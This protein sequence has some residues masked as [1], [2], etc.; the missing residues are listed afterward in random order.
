MTWVVV[1]LG[2]WE[3]VALAKGV[4]EEDDPDVVCALC[5]VLLVVDA[6]CVTTFF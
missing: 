1:R 6:V 5:G 2:V 4:V 3:V